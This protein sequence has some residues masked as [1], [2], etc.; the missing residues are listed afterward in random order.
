MYNNCGVKTVYISY[1]YRVALNIF[2]QCWFSQYMVNKCSSTLQLQRAAADF[3][4]LI[5]LD[6]YLFCHLATA[7]EVSAGSSSV[8]LCYYLLSTYH[9]ALFITRLKYLDMGNTFLSKIL[10]RLSEKKDIRH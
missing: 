9:I 3:I 2:L 1:F 6:I 8:L 7:Q 5:M 10:L 4:I